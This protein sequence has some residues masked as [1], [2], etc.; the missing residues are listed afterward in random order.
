MPA[1]TRTRLGLSATRT[2]VAMMS[3]ML[4]GAPLAVAA[5]KVDTPC[6]GPGRRAQHGDWTTVN[7]PRYAA[8]PRTVSA[9]AIFRGGDA[10]YVSNG[11]SLARSGDF[12]C[13][14]KNVFRL[15][16]AP[17][18]SFPY[19][20]AN[21]KIRSIVASSKTRAVLLVEETTPLGSRP[22]VVVVDGSS[23]TMADQ[24]L[25]PQGT[26]EFFE[27]SGYGSATIYLGVDLAGGAVDVIYA[28]SNGGATWEVRSNV[29]NT[30]GA[31]I[32]GLTA[33]P[34]NPAD[35]W[36]WGT[37]GLFRS[38]DGARNFAEIDAFSES[39]H[40]GPVDV[41]HTPGSKIRVIG[42]RR[43]A[44]DY[45]E[46]LR[47]DNGGRTWLAFPAPPRVTSVAHGNTEA[48]ILASSTGRVYAYNPATFS[49]IDFR[50]PS[51]DTIDLTGDHRDSGL[52][53]GRTARTLE[54]FLGDTTRATEVID[55]RKPD[56][57]IPLLENPE[58]TAGRAELSGGRPKVR[59][60]I[61][62]SAT[63]SYKL[64]V[65]RRNLPVDIFFLVDTTNSMEEVNRGLALAFANIVQELAG[66]GV[67]AQY[68]LAEYRAYP[69]FFPP[70]ANEPN[71]V[72]KLR[73]QL[74]DPEMLGPVLE[75]LQTGGGGRFD[76]QL[77]AL[78]HMATG[79]GADFPPMQPAPKDSYDVEAG[80]GA[81]FRGKTGSTRI[82]ILATNEPFGRP[83]EPR[84]GGVDNGGLGSPDI[85]SPN[86]VIRELN[87]KNITPL[88]LGIDP[89]EEPRMMPDLVKLAKGTGAA[90]PAPGVDCNGDGAIDIPTGGPLVC[91]LLQG[92]IQSD[93]T[94]LVPAIVNLVK[95]VPA[96]TSPSLEVTTGTEVVTSI[97]PESYKSVLLQA[98]QALDFDVTVKCTK[99]L[100][101]K[102][103]PVEL[104][105][106]AGGTTLG[107]SQTL[108]ICTPPARPKIPPFVG[109]A[110]Q[111]LVTLVPLIPPAPPPPVSQLST[112]TQAQ[113]QAQAQS[114]MATQEQKQPQLAYAHSHRAE[115][116]EA[117]AREYKMS[118]FRDRTPA[119]P[120][121]LLPLGASA[122]A[123][124]FG[125]GAAS[126]A[127]SRARLAYARQVRR[128]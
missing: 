124:A 85:P 93:A 44:N 28:S 120:P 22:H 83:G 21:A 41:W 108:V 39:S 88:T 69:D 46:L 112:S 2:V 71:F 78:H 117:A 109:P 128:R 101:G 81:N 62:E 52:V 73:Q 42:F 13:A 32:E 97:T 12:G 27:V 77:G 50:A 127:R 57:D 37:G 19:S 103:V 34:I 107:E 121:G 61:G 36:A 122:L 17:T 126:V 91:P 80:T 55:T 89:H 47:S 125:F 63:L 74:D 43:D 6:S 98:T 67:A 14:W 65:P 3:V 96:K 48:T 16:P 35:V 114:A 30:L 23:A 116:Q 100:A 54:L 87:A 33:D 72:Y 90:A 105:A 40:V 8:G 76:A 24:G 58:Q 5:P 118:S 38:K 84:T 51:P 82:V 104:L 64:K 94:N 115:L 11:I 31:G 70:R 92:Q 59:L 66:E 15:P 29:Q 75:G 111:T 9:F 53:A 99:D 20:S 123:M 26:G 60:D 86:Q 68:G 102:K 95:A 10:T 113:S 56:I 4:V 45:P 25:P 7:A 106:K 79:E 18:A 119:S 49:W 1:F 110:V